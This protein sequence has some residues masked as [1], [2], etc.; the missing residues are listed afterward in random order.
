MTDSVAPLEEA[1]DVIIDA[2]GETLNLCYQCGLCD[3]ACPWNLVKKFMVRKLIREAQF[4]L[5]ELG[6]E[7]IWQC[8]TCGNCVA[9][10]PRGVKIIDVLVSLR[11][12]A[13]QNNIL[14]QTI[15]VARGS[16]IGEGNPWNGK[17]EERGN[18]SGELSVKTFTKD[19]EYLYFPCCAQIYDQR[20]K[21]IA[22]AT[23]NV[24]KA[25]GVDFGILGSELVCCGESIRKAGEEE[26][27]MRLAKENIKSFIEKGVKKIVVSSPHCYQAFKNEYSE[28]MVNFH[29]VHISQLLLELINEGKLKFRKKYKKTVTYHDPCF[30]GRHNHQYDQARAVLNKV[31][32]L[33][34]VEMIDSQS[35]SLCCGGGGA[36]IWMDTPKN[37]RL[38]NLRL[39]Q[40]VKT[41]AGLLTTFCPYCIMNFE[42]SRLSL[43]SNNEINIRDVIEIVQEVI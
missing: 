6:S 18:W 40:A 33:D 35:N 34:V 28:F 5:P 8:A 20:T 32:G 7:A 23:V 38:S 11:K 22:I 1:I 10:C 39:E 3:T 26:L 37:E 25:A 2:G 19:T 17:R 36:R 12:I 9:R 43:E 29:V 30:L 14:P 27:F 24:L 42:D 15:R 4:G 21:K 31:P 41:G 16:L 13:T